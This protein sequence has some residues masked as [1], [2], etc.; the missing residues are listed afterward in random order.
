MTCGGFRPVPPEYSDWYRDVAANIAAILAP[1]AP[2]S[3]TSRSTQTKG[4]AVRDGLIAHRRS[5]AGVLL[6][7][8]LA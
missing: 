6:I 2:T 4:A 7:S 5:G 8:L 1:M 3:S